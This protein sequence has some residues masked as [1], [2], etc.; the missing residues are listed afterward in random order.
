MDRILVVAP[1][2]CEPWTEGRKNLVRDLLHALTRLKHEIE[3]ITFWRDRNSPTRLRNI[4]ISGRHCKGIAHGL[5]YQHRKLASVLSS[6]RFDSVLHFPY[7]SF[8]SFRS[9]VNNQSMLHIDRTCGRHRT[10]CLTVLYSADEHADLEMLAKRLSGLATGRGS[11]KDIPCVDFGISTD[12]WSVPER[13]RTPG[14]KL[15]FMAGMWQPRQGRLEH[16]IDRRGLGL[17]LQLGDRLASRGAS[18]TVASPLLDSESLSRR[19]RTH[20]L[21][22][23][24]DDRLRL[25]PVAKIPNIYLEADLF[26]FPYNANIRVFR[27]TSVIESMMSGTPAVISDQHFLRESIGNNTP[28]FWFRAG[29]AQ[30]LFSTIIHALD[31]PGETERKADAARQY[32]SKHWRIESTAQRLLDI[33]QTL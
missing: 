1:E 7:G 32:A 27:P 22:T 10:R 4:R 15:L 14:R 18:L 13:P 8:R 5:L 28:V 19:L 12:H 26:I 25:V 17:L 20:E 2:I 23:W 6:E 21:N 24:P 30:S 16:V 11:P 29:N 31:H 3:L 9:I 33:L